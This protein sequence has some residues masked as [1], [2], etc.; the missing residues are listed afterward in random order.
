M[1]WND[2]YLIIALEDQYVRYLHNNA[3]QISSVE[4]HGGMVDTHTL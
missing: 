2:A 1:C 4:M 3:T